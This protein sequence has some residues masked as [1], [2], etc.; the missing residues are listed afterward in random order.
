MAENN[1]L[2]LEDLTEE[3]L[4]FRL[5]RM[6]QLRLIDQLMQQQL[7]E[8]LEEQKKQERI[9]KKIKVIQEF[10]VVCYDDLLD[11]LKWRCQEVLAMVDDYHKE[12]Q[13]RKS[14]GEPVDEQELEKICTEDVAQGLKEIQLALPDRGA[15][16][17]DP[18]APLPPQ[19]EAI[20]EEVAKEPV[21]SSDTPSNRPSTKTK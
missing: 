8:Q 10:I 7:E 20:T 17:L 4:L 16:G 1:Q 14:Q 13:L 11:D 3:Q 21:V 5:T 12:C 2:N 6:R 15:L 18:P 19:I 9:K